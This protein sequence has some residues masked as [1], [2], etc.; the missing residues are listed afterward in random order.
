MHILQQNV[1]KG[2]LWEVVLVDNGS[3]DQT[4]K[5]AADTWHSTVPLK[6]ISEMRHGITHARACGIEHASFEFVSLIDDDNWIDSNWVN[7][8]FQT[9]SENPEIAMCGGRNEAVFEVPLPAWFEHVKTCYAVGKQGNITSDITDSRGFLW[10]AGMSFRKSAYL[11][12]IAAGFTY[13]TSGRVGARLS[14]G[15]DSELSIA[16]IAAGFRLWY[17]ETLNLQHFMP[18]KRLTWPQAIGTFSGLGESDFQLDMYRYAIR[19]RRFPLIRIY[20]SL[21]PYSLVYFGWRFVTLLNNHENNPR[22]LS[23]IARKIYIFTALRNI[24]RV[25]GLMKQIQ[26]FCERAGTLTKSV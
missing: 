1:R 13:H 25:R 3:S 12:I 19:K 20:G 2:I 8:V 7:E 23:Y 24:K 6:I 10:G 21:I 11:K 16:F 9:F 5:V 17:I 26:D 15:D 22:Y 14:A 18:E 4:A